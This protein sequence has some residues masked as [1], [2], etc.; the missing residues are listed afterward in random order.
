MTG[1]HKEITN[2]AFGLCIFGSL[3]IFL[4][5]ICALFCGFDGFAVVAGATAIA[6]M[7]AGVSGFTIGKVM[8]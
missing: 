5:V 6:G 8:R 2:R 4:M 7:I 1:E 3:L